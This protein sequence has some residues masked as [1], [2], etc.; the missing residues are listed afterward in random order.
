MPSPS[1]PSL[2]TAVTLHSLTN[3][4]RTP[5]AIPPVYIVPLPADGSLHG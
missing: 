4:R 5:D 3:A 2:A 1:P